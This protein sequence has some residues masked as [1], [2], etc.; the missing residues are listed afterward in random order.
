MGLEKHVD[1]VLKETGID[2]NKWTWENGLLVVNG[3]DAD[4]IMQALDDSNEFGPTT[5]DQELQKIEIGNFN[6]E[7]HNKDG[8]PVEGKKVLKNGKPL[9]KMVGEDGNVYAIISRVVKALDGVGMK[10]KSDDFLIESTKK[11]QTY[12][13]VIQLVYEYCEV[14]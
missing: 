3:D 6:E 13:G 7:R 1:Q 12:D 5:Y 11:S 10:Q 2:E 8:E 14:E 9:V 4:A